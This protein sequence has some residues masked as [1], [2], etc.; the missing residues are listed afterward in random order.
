M[1]FDSL[2]LSAIAAEVTEAFVGDRVKTVQAIDPLTIAI[3]FSRKR[4]LLISAHAE[5]A[6]AHLLRRDGSRQPQPPMFCMLLRKYLEDSRLRAVRQPSFDRILELDFVRGEASVTLVAEI[7]GRH[8]NILL[9]SSEGSIVGLIKPVAAARNRFRELRVGCPYVAPPSG[10]KVSPLE[11][12]LEDAISLLAAN[13]GSASTIADRITSAW[14]GMSRPIVDWM[15]AKAGLRRD[16]AWND[17][18]GAALRP[19]LE[20]LRQIVAAREYAPTLKQGKK[21]TDVWA[22]P[23]PGPEDSGQ[24]VT[25][26]GS[27]SEAVEEF[28]STKAEARVMSASRGQVLSTLGHLASRERRKCD[29]FTRI[30]EDASRS[31]EIRLWAQSLLAFQDRVDSG[32]AQVVLPDPETGNRLMSIPL[33]PQANVVENAEVLFQRARRSERARRTVRERFEASRVLAL[34]LDKAERTVRDAESLRDLQ[35][36]IAGLPSEWGLEPK[37]AGERGSRGEHLPSKQAVPVLPSGIRRVMAPGG[38]EI[39]YGRSSADNDVLTTR[40]ARPNDIWLHARGESSAHVVIRTQNQPDRVPRETLLLAANVAASHSASKH[41]SYVPVDYTLRKFVV[42][43]KG[44]PPGAVEYRG[45]K[46][47]HVQPHLSDEGAGNGE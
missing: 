26:V 44:S 22:M 33:D 43:R 18:R 19:G 5:D 42:K 25:P 35:C 34:A 16:E 24:S 46:T 12:S 10:S 3:V 41:S 15:V 36:V 7:M 1:P 40:I 6:R 45:E 47:L 31:V 37:P 4:R 11:G 8:S 29:D 28:Y 30:E 21:T 23:F 20:K 9:R 2:V 32:A 38:Y 27:M 14:I 17:L 13:D 39:L